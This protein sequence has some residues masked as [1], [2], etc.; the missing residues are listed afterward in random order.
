MDEPMNCSKNKDKLPDVGVYVPRRSSMLCSLRIV[1]VRSDHFL[2]RRY[3]MELATA[4]RA[5]ELRV[6]RSLELLM[7]GVAEL[8]LRADVRED[9]YHQLVDAGC[10]QLRDIVL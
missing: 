5:R 1:P 7:A 10:C 3:V 9:L 6:F 2:G 8:G 4:S